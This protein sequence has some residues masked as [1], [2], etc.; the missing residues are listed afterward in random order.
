MFKGIFVMLALFALHA[1]N[2]SNT[3]TVVAIT[4]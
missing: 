4:Q 2:S 3:Q 1:Y